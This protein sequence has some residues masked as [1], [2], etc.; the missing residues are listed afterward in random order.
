MTTSNYQSQVKLLLR[1]LPH[2]AIEE[3]FALKGG[4]AI[5]L[6]VRDLPRLSV[7]LDLTY[8][9]LADRKES[10]TAISAALGRIRDRLLAAIPE[11]HFP[12]QPTQVGDEAKLTCLLGF[13]NVKIEVN[14]VLRGVVWP[15]R[16]L[17]VTDAVQDEFSL[18]AAMAV[19]SHAELF[20]GKLCAALDRQH[21]RDLFDV[22]Q[23]YE[24][25]GLTDEVVQGF[26]VSLVSHGRPMH[27]LIRPNLQ[28]HQKS[29]AAQ[30]TGMTRLPFTYDD[31]VATRTR[32]VAE[33]PARLTDRDRNFLLSFKSG[34]PDWQLSPAPGIES[35]PAVQWK[36]QNIRKLLSN[37]RKHATQF[38]ALEKALGG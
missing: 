36:L 34:D 5:N 7:D 15:T 26:L 35:L 24:N 19:V 14:T 30:F 33:L 13:A 9:P 21:P 25:E 29:F 11:I 10:L 1:I 22:N 12:S 27:E 28:D 38:A 2:V 20:G 8:V 23:L 3:D 17:S 6:F 37:K 32:L 18:H 16:L 31:F 4:T